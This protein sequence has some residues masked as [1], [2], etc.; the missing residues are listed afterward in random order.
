M[1]YKK[2][3]RLWRIEKGIEG[4]LKSQRESQRD[5]H[6]SQR[7]TDEQLKRTD[8]QLKRT[9]EE[10][11]FLTRKTDEEIRKTEAMVGKLTDGWGKFVEGLVEPSLP[12]VF[13][14]FGLRIEGISQRVTRHKDGETMEID[15]LGVG[16]QNG[17]PVVLVVEAKSQIGIRDVKDYE[18]RYRRFEEFFKEYGSYKKVGVVCGVRLTEGIVRYASKKGFYVLGASGDMMVLKATPRAR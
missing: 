18:E 6:E 7:K 17:S 4:L 5:L 14:K 10:I 8:E 13:E 12:V 15:L 11:K 3:D 1:K 9:D 2:N 16:S